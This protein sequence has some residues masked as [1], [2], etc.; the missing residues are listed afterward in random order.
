LTIGPF[1]LVSSG[2]RAR[3]TLARQTSRRRLRRCVQIVLRRV[4][5]GGRLRFGPM[6]LDRRTASLAALAAVAALAVAGCGDDD[7][8]AADTTAAEQAGGQPVATVEV[9]ETE[10]KLD[11]PN[12]TVEESGTVEFEVVNDGEV[13]HSL[14]IESEEEEFVS[15]EIAAGESTT[16]TA[17]LAPGE[18]EYYCPI[19][20]HKELGMDGTLTVAGGGGGAAGG[21]GETETETETETESGDDSGGGGSGY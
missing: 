16:L 10:Y 7:E 9:T 6:S 19:A 20:N 5:A 12:P 18:Y 2:K 3:L 21:S 17:D 1:F 15:D 8:E 13:T 11:P 4:T 14:E